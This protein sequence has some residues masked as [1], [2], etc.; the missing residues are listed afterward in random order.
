MIHREMAEENGGIRW[1]LVLVASP[2]QGHMTPMLQLGTYL[3]SK[4]FSITI[5]HPEFNP[6]NSL[7]HPDFVFLPLPDNISSPGKF[8]SFLGFL[9]ALNDNC[10]PHLREH[11]VQIINA[12]KEKSEK[13][14]V[15]IIHDNLMVFGGSV[16]GDLGLPSIIMHS[17]SAAFFPAYKI[18]P[19]LHKDGRFPVHDPLMQ[20]IVPELDPFRYKDLPFID[21]PMQDALDSVNMI[22]PN[23]SPSAF[24]WN[25]LQFLEPSALTR[26]RQQYQVPIFSIGPLHKI[27]PTPST[28]FL[29]ED[30]SCITWLDK[31]EPKSVLYVSLGSVANM[32][33]KVATEIAWG[34]ANSNQPFLW[35]VR[36]GSVRGFEWIEFLPE[37]LVDEMKGRGLIVKW[38]PQKEV[39]AHNA[40]GG[41]W[42][43]CGWNST[44]ESVCEGVPMLCQPFGVDQLL[45]ARYLSYVWKMGIEIVMERREIEGVIRRVLVDKE[46]EEMRQRGMEIQENVKLALSHGG[47]SQNSLIDLV[48]FIL[49]L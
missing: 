2:L 6:P 18:I 9:Q 20:E 8:T 24:I 25:T 35:V 32:D 40:V 37:G 36:P 31:Q 29:K 15:V 10:K 7:N 42:S 49:S 39:L 44:L 19:Q 38:A 17:S 48:D 34:L 4:G 46:G 21:L 14:S 26:I 23:T 28:S 11:L 12:Q 27:A 47:S 33:E 1:R 22:I 16:A 13:E 3:H 45:N 43:H 30:T 5:A 41:F